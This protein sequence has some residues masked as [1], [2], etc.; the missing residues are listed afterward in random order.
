MK[1]KKTL[2]TKGKNATKKD[3]QAFRDLRIT[4]HHLIRFYLQD[5]KSK[6]KEARILKAKPSACEF[7]D[8]LFAVERPVSEFDA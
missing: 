2:A 8:T 5:S 7:V 1:A 3:V 6:T 4:L